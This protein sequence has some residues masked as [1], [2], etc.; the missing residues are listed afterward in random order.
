MMHAILLLL[1]DDNVVRADFGLTLLLYAAMTV[2]GTLLAPKPDIE[3]AKPAGLGDFQFPT[4]TEGRRIPQSWG[5][6]KIKGPNVIWYGDLLQEAIT[7]KIKTSLFSSK[8]VVRGYRYHF[9]VQFALHMG[10]ADELTKVWIGDDLVFE[11]SVVHGGTFTI[12]ED[13]LFGGDELGNGGVVGTLQF[14]SG[15]NNQA[16][17]DYLGGTTISTMAIHTAGAS[18]L[19]GSI[20]TVAGGTFTTPA[21]FLVTTV[22]GGVPTAGYMI[23]PGLYSVLPATPAATTVVGPGTGLTIDL[24]FGDKHQD[25][26]GKTPAYRDLAY[27][28]PATERIYVGNSTS[29]KPWAFETRTTP[30]PIALTANRHKVNGFDANHA[31]VLYAALTNTEWGKGILAAQVDMPSFVTAGNTLYAEGNG[32]SFLLDREEDVTDLIKRIEDQ[33]DG[34]VY[35][36]PI[37]EKW[38]VVLVRDNYDPLTVPELDDD[39]IIEVRGFSRG[40]WQGTHNQVRVPFTSRDD[41]YRDTYGFAQDMANMR[42]VGKTV[43]TSITHPGCKDRTLANS[44]AWR[45]LRTLA[46]PLAKGDFVVDRTLYGV[47]P[48]DVVTFTNAELNL[49]RLPMRVRGVRYGEL[50]DG[51][52]VL[53]CVQD[54]FRASDGSFAPPPDS[55]WQNPSDTL[56][57][58][59]TLGQLAFEAPRA[60]TLRDPDSDT[61]TTDKLYAAARRQGPEV[62]FKIMERHAAGTPAGAFTEVGQVFSFVRIGS[63]S[64]ALP[65]GSAYP[66]ST[67][68]LLPAPDTQ[69]AL[70]IDF[71]DITDLLGLGTDL[72]TL[73]MCGNEFFLVSSAQTSGL[74]TQL[75]SLYRGALDSAQE[76]HAA[77]APFYLLFL[78]GGMSESTIAAGQNVHVKLIPRTTSDTL[79][80]ASAIQI[81][82]TMAN[83]TRRP[84]P[85]SE[86]SINGSRFDPTVDLEGGAGVGELIGIDLTYKRRD[87]RTVDEVAALLTDA[88][89]IDPTYPAANTTTHKVEVVNITGTPTSLFTQALGSGTSGSVT[90]LDILI[91]T[92]GALPTALRFLLRSAH[93]FEGVSYDSRYDLAW[94]MTIAST[95]TG[96]FEFTALD[97]NDV[98]AA[99]TVVT[100]GTNHVFTLSSA[101]T[102]G[103]VQYRLNGGAYVNL[104]TAGL[105][106]GTIL[107]VAL[108]NG[109]LLEI[110][111]TST[112]VGAKKLLTMA[113]GTAKAFGVLFV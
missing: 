9:G 71:P 47:L 112:D 78:G 8:K 53:S 35:Q 17:S 88:A 98:S 54:V 61:P 85:P 25:I 99:F 51:Q 57:A 93:T 69:S 7:E 113:V 104:I 32:F 94:D 52:I 86:M 109:D 87:F 1:A 65:V 26:G 72:T 103:A 91:A 84:Y 74:N 90:R 101:F 6:N 39:N 97:T 67:L 59:P 66:L 24:T 60:L 43:A 83:R 14:F 22:S 68:T 44:L 63:L 82:L 18:Y 4:A 92:D 21:K 70:E 56:V 50:K 10:V 80:E 107:A 106:T 48:G 23:D 37:S 27:I 49:T 110:R 3:N 15:T 108:T 13:E 79:A 100:A 38:K 16:A 105:T 76:A 33:I 58:F 36:D 111:H 77:G 34:A 45:A 31:N 96:L 89:T 12:D 55:G 28:V 19:M 42:I 46:T 40:T 41:S 29:I 20:V 2:I 81:A 95:L 30:N 75:N 11:G 5:T 64:A 62:M 73:C 102:L